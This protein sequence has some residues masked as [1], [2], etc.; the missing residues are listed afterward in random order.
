MDSC[1]FIG[2]GVVDGMELMTT[3][4]WFPASRR[5]NGNVKVEV[6]E[7]TDE[8]L[9]YFDRYEGVKNNFYNREEVDINVNGKTIKGYMYIGDK[10]FEMYTGWKIREDGDYSAHMLEVK[11]E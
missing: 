9:E 7:V 10:V 4:I 2:E 11:R 3:N 8:Q 5:G 1:K 6:Y